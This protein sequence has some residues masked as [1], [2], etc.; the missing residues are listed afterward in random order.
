MGT[1]FLELIAEVPVF[2]VS[3]RPGL[4]ALADLLDALEQG[5][6]APAAA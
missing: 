4:D 5:V 6:L 2:R 1:Q 3:L